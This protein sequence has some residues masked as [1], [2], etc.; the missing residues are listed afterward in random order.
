MS[1]KIF[2]ADELNI[3][4][5]N[6]NWSQKEF[7][8]QE[9]IFFLKDV[10]KIL[11]L[12]PLKV[13]RKVREILGRNKSPWEIMGVKKL[14]NHWVIRMKVFASFYLENLVSRVRSIEKEWDGNTLLKQKGVFYLTE[15]CT[16]IPFSTHQLRYQ[17]KQNPRSREEYG[18]WKDKELGLY[19]ADMERFA[20]WIKSL[21]KGNFRP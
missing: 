19:L 7:L 6:R 5:F 20:P 10:V 21:W 15:V 16:L 14:W 17:A 2:E 13:K 12:D 8:G 11:D 4:Q 3:T 9:G 1:K 18:V